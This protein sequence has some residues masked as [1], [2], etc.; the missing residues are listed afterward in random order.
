MKPVFVE[1]FDGALAHHLAKEWFP[2]K[3]IIRGQLWP[4]FP[5]VRHIHRKKILGHCKFIVGRTLDKGAYSPQH[6]V[7]HSQAGFLAIECHRAGRNKVGLLP[8]GSVRPIPTERQLVRSPNKTHVVANAVGVRMV[9][10][11]AD[12]IT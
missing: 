9:F 5:R 8:V 4:G 3:T 10:V 2:A 7:A 11:V 6:K 1:I 12:R